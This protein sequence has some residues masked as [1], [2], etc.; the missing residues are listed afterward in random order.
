MARNRTRWVVGASI[1]A[2]SLTL[3]GVAVATAPTGS[4]ASEVIGAGSTDQNFKLV[5]RPDTNTVVASFTI[6]PNSSTGWHTH[7]GRT[8]VTVKTGTFTVYHADDCEPLVYE[9]G[10]AFVEL[11]SSIHVGRNETAE[12]VELGVGFFRVP[13]DGSPRIDQPQPTTCDVT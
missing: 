1:V 2:A 3:S 5:A 8:L 9:P 7:P 6:G 11:P 4:V 12:P 13:I 10:D